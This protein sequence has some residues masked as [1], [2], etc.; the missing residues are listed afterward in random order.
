MHY[1][2]YFKYETGC[3]LQR[4]EKA[5]ILDMH[6]NACAVPALETARVTARKM[7]ATP[8]RPLQ[9]PNWAVGWQAL[10]LPPALLL[11]IKRIA[12]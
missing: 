1:I 3:R 11:Y 4:I 12:V 5:E 7:R 9:G 8:A 10:L 6:Y 2:A